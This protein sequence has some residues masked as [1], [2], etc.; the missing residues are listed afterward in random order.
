MTS[1]ISASNLF[2]AMIIKPFVASRAEQMLATLVPLSPNTSNCVEWAVPALGAFR[3][4][5]LPLIEDFTELSSSKSVE[6][7]SHLVASGAFSKVQFSQTFYIFSH[8][9]C[10]TFF[11]SSSVFA[12]SHALSHASLEGDLSNARSPS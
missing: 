10:K 4:L 11:L 2:P 7:M 3:H 6:Q 12:R 5:K 8:I 9:F 1:R